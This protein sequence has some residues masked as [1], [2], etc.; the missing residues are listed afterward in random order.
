MIRTY[1]TT[2]RTLDDMIYIIKSMHPNNEGLRIWKLENSKKE[3]VFKAKKVRVLKVKPIKPF[4]EYAGRTREVKVIDI[5]TGN[6]YRSISSLARK[7]EVWPQEM[8]RIIDRGGYGR[9]LKQING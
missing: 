4:S 6:V 9:Y 8:S 1:I 5:K 3:L 7:L 2:F